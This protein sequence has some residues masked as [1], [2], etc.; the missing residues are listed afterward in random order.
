MTVWVYI[1][2]VKGVGDEDHLCISA[3]NIDPF[4]RPAVT[5]VSM[6]FS[7]LPQIVRCS[8][9][10]QPWTPIGG[11]TACRFTAEL[12]VWRLLGRSNPLMIPLAYQIRKIEIMT[13]VGLRPTN[14]S[15]WGRLARKFQHGLVN[16]WR[17]RLASA[18]M[19]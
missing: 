16:G 6:L 13:Q 11:Q 4:R 5:P 14:C 10:G 19:C 9:E 3:S 15:R 12:N 1:N 18:D 7:T 8:A 2:T 17:R